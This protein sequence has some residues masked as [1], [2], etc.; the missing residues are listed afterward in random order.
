MKQ[1]SWSGAG[2]LGRGTCSSDVLKSRLQVMER[3]KKQCHSVTHVM[4]TK[5]FMIVAC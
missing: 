2:D 1:P 5:S 4:S 3:H